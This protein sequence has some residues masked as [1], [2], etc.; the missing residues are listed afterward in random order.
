MLDIKSMTFNKRDRSISIA[1][2]SVSAILQSGGNVNSIDTND[3]SKKDLDELE[4]PEM[5]PI[6]YGK[7]KNN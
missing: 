6:G 1:E 7:Y 2:P 4:S 3:N 5:F